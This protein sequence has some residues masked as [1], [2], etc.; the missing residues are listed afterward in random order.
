MF[1]FYYSGLVSAYH[2]TEMPLYDVLS[3]L[4]QTARVITWEVVMNQGTQTPEKESSGVTAIF[5]GPSID[6]RGKFS[7]DIDISC[8]N[9][10]KLR[11][12][13]LEG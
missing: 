1:A 5:T 8:L 11:N 4:S 10:V 2:K 9:E 7:Y 12:V 6:I 3:V 13:V